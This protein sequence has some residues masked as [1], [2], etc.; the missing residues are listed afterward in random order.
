MVTGLFIGR[1]QP[2]HNG[3]LNAIKESLSKAGQLVIAVGSS[4]RSHEP[5]NLFTLGERIEV[6]H[7]VLKEEGLWEKCLIVGI[8]DVNNNSLWVAH[9]NAL[10]PRYDMV[11]SG[12]PLVTRLFKEAGVEVIAPSFYERGKLEGK[13]IR[14]LMKEDSPEWRSHLPKAAV[15]FIDEINAIERLQDILGS[16]SHQEVKG[17]E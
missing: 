16:D 15:D 17:E 8:P 14:L 7:R 10:T 9:L 5:E 13:Q 3:H 11:F 2:F 4:Q 1:F 6:I 12:N